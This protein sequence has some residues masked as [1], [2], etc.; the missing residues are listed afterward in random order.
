LHF[1]VEKNNFDAPNSHTCSVIPL[2][3]VNNSVLFLYPW[4]ERKK[5][6]EKF[7]IHVEK[8]DTIFHGLTDHYQCF[9]Q[10][11]KSTDTENITR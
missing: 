1:L 6:K 3:R 8:S 7:R 2:W 4:K 5:K 11:S 9:G 10:I